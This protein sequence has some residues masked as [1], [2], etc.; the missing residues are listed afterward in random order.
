MLRVFTG[1]ND[2][3][4]PTIPPLVTYAEGMVAVDDIGAADLV[5]L[6]QDDV[7]DEYSPEQLE[8]ALG[9]PLAEQD[10]LR[11]RYHRLIDDAV[12][13]ELPVVVMRHSD[14][15]RTE[16]IPN[17][18]TF[19]TSLSRTGRHERDFCLAG[20]ALPGIAT[21]EHV[22][23]TGWRRPFVQ[24]PSVG[25][26]GSARLS[27]LSAER[28]ARDLATLVQRAPFTDRIPQLETRLVKAAWNPGQM[29][30]DRALK[31][32]EKSDRVDTDIVRITRGYINATEEDKVRNRASYLDN[33][34]RNPYALCVR[35][36][37]NFS[38]RLYEAMCL[39]RIPLFVDAD[40]VLP[41]DDEVDWRNAFI[42]IE[43]DQI[44]TAPDRV[45]EFHAMIDEEQLH[46]RQAHVRHLWENY[47]E[48]G[49]FWRRAGQKVTQLIDHD[50][51][52]QR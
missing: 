36:R 38:Y 20:F 27:D 13:R 35:G 12:T 33:M 7:F 31:A 22:G 23:T 34:L 39:Y 18:I 41:F 48:E 15:A 5:L 51:G 17:S 49:A 4:K 6:P 16:R 9:V 21:H 47:C 52:T 40:S 2:F 46:A 24:R 43:H 29:L 14:F 19:Q 10:Q 44:D 25:F 30:R 3:P 32:L 42:W 1:W 45:A 8:G 11:I 37:G 26:Q 28:I 50:R